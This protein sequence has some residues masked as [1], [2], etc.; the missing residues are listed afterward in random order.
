MFAGEFRWRLAV[1]VLAAATGRSA[2]AQVEPTK[3]VAVDCAAGATIAHAMTLGDERKPMVVV[4]SGTC[5]EAVSI[6]RSDVTLR[7]GPGGGGITGADPAV[8][9][10]TVTGSRATIDGLVIT[11][12]RNG[13]R[14]SGAAGLVV[15]NTTVSGTGRSGLSLG[16]GTSAHLDRCTIQDNPRDGVAIEAAHAVILGSL[17]TRNGRIGVVVVDGGSARIGIDGQNV[18]SGSTITENG[19]SGAPGGMLHI[20]DQRGVLAV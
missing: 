10:V 14:A 4:V 16:E 8:D 20:P 11:G 15:R 17:V 19:A 1:A 18:P 6:E 2:L 5:T 7:A 3:D 12:G 9:A 13:I